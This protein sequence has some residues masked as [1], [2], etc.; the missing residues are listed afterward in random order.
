MSRAFAIE[1]EQAEGALLRLLGTIERRGFA[2][3]GL[4]A[5]PT[6][7]GGLSV[8]LSVDGE[9]D[10]NVLCRQLERLVDVRE[11]RLLPEPPE[12]TPDTFQATWL[13]G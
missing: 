3:A 12:E 6:G 2:L 5:D 13:Q 11:V 10:P 8:R 9:R 7:S 4:Q 1:L